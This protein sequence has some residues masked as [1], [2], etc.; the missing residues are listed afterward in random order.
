MEDARSQRSRLESQ[1][2][3]IAIIHGGMFVY[4]NQTFLKLF[5]ISDLHDLFGIPLLDMVEAR[6]HDRLRDHLSAAGTVKAGAKEIPRARLAM[7]TTGGDSFRA[8]MSSHST[9][10]DGEQCV[11]VSIRTR[12]DTTLWGYIRNL[13]WALYGS[14][15][16]LLLLLT[17]PSLLLLNLNI[18]N[19]PK[20]YFPPDEP[21]VVVDNAVREKFP[22]DQVVVMLFEGVALFS[23]GFLKAYDQLA[24]RLEA[25][26]Q[27]ADVLA[28][29]TQDHISGSEEGFMV[30]PL[31]DTDKLYR[32]HPSNRPAAVRADP[33]ARGFLMSE[34]GSAL[35]MVVI[36]Q[37]ANTSLLRKELLDD[38]LQEV[39]AAR[40]GGYLSAMAGNVPVDVAQLRSMLRDNIIF[41]PATTTIGLLLIWLLFHR[42]FAVVVG[43]IAIGVVVS[44]TIALYVLVGR[45]FTLIS[46]II[47]PLLSA[48]TIAALVHLFNAL[49]YAAQRGL[50]GKFRVERALQEIRQPA[51]YTALTTAAGLASLGASPITPIAT[52]GLLS[53][54]GVVLI[55]VVVIL[56]VPPIFARWDYSDWPKRKGGVHWMDVALSY[57][58]RVG[59]RHSGV[60]LGV[61]GVLLL[62]GVPQLFNITVETNVQEFFQPTHE[63]RRSTDR[64]DQRLVGTMPLRVVFTASAADGIKLPENLREIRKFQNWAEQLPEVDNSL[65]PADFI[66]EMNWGFNEEKPRFRTIPGNQRLI[67][68]YLFIYDGE[69]LFDLVDRD[70]KVGLVNL[71]LNVHSASE[72]NRVME[73]IRGYL[74]QNIGKGMTWDIA[75]MGRLF[76]DMEELLVR[77][78]VYSL[79]GALIL[80]FL[81]MLVLWRSLGQ[82]L[83]CMIPNLS[84]ILLIFIFMGIFGIWLDMATAM[85]ASVAAGIAVDDTIHVFHGFI[86]RVKAG[87]RPVAALVRTYRQAGRAVLTTTI[88]LSAQF[89]VLVTSEFIPT[90]NFGLLTSIGLVAALL[91]DLMLLPAIL[92]FIYE[93]KSRP[94]KK[95]KQFSRSG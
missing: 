35:A 46:S 71:N 39:E 54:L 6:H 1:H 49:H 36:P 95:I 5:G 50:I 17:L 63:A 34:D 62:F 41:I 4:A 31:I 12:E 72:I 86:K 21:A 76:S 26:P 84:P 58:S 69:D 59:I 92:V 93:P 70:Y 2:A 24:E 44:T 68:Q 73:Q 29:T 60:V 55:Y 90:G 14:I 83:L 56:L 13:P 10:Y 64:I 80:I 78:Q 28:V 47:P 82:A 16:L 61:T 33:I 52:F 40:L 23:D 53:A 30:E 57:L 37:E 81:L 94:K 65:S 15:A 75:G 9:L 87:S 18:N 43:G 85:I 11:Q 22:A 3:P 67:S 79:G 74:D 51:R 48:L 42:P 91:F 77:G 19:A 38:I 45:P 7:T 20:V 8:V 25:H 66:E 89:M 32:S 88:I 27:V